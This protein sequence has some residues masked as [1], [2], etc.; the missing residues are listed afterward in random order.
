MYFEGSESSREVNGNYAPV[1]CEKVFSN[2]SAVTLGIGCTSQ[3]VSA[4]TLAVR[5]VKRRDFTF[6]A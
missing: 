6:R 3:F 2:I 4:S 1:A 5:T